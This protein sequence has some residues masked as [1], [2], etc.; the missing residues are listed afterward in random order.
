[1]KAL[2]DNLK[3]NGD[4]LEIGFGLGYSAE[5]IQKI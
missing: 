3:P 2:V 1:M 5:Q 4:V